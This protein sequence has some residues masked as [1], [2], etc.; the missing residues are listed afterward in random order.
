MTEVEYD[1]LAQFWTEFMI[2]GPTERQKGLDRR[3]LAQDFMGWIDAG[4]D[5]CTGLYSVED[6]LAFFNEKEQREGSPI[7]AAFHD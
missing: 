3:G 7:L 2:I 4:D 1:G 6:I 5:E